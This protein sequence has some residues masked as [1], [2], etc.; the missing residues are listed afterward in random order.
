MQQPS[1]A[2]GSRPVVGIDVAKDHLDCFIDPINQSLRLANNADGIAQLVERLRALDVE[3]VLIEATGRYHRRLAADLLDAQ[4]PVTIVNPQRAR[5][6]ARSMGRLE[7]TDHI[8]ARMLASFARAAGASHRR[9]VKGS[10]QQTVLDDLVSRRR[11]LVAV[12]VAEK[13]RLA[14]SGLPKL[15]SRQGRQLLR[16]LEQQIEDLDREI[17]KLIE[18]DDD[19][20]N[21][22]DLLTS[23]PGV[24]DNTAHQLIADL[25]ELGTLSRGRIAKL[26]GLAPLNCDSGAHRGQRRIAGGRAAVRVALYMA[27]LSAMRFC[28]RFKQHAQRLKQMGKPFKVIITACMRKLLITL[29]Q[30]LKTN[31]SFRSSI[32]PA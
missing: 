15:A 13:N 28:P 21:K 10:P 18:Q 6:F 30:M 32:V 1:S 20:R 27:T 4:I 22:R 24:G 16:L 3:L 11:A 31:T 8:D 19:W 12:R 5:E 14:E 2:A 29:N 9:C 26:V 23:V 25:P 7:K 17:A